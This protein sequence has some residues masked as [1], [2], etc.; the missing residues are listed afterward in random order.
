MQLDYVPIKAPL[1][2]DRRF[3]CVCILHDVSAFIPRVIRNNLSAVRDIR[4]KAAQVFICLSMITC[5]C[6]THLESSGTTFLH[7]VTSDWRRC[8]FVNVCIYY[9][10]WP[11][12]FLQQHVFICFGWHCKFFF[13]V[14]L[15]GSFLVLRALFCIQTKEKEF[16]EEQRVSVAS[17]T[18]C[19][20]F[21]SFLREFKKK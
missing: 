2:S 19:S 20:S 1:T 14:T 9:M 11:F 5:I 15:L 3:A 4:L 17:V 7:F 16:Y 12:I 10:N 6:I 13:G 8:R 21:I 18:R